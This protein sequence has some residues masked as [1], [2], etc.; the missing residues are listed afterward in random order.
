MSAAA[1]ALFSVSGVAGIATAAFAS[2]CGWRCFSPRGAELWLAR[3]GTQPALTQICSYLIAILPLLALGSLFGA[4]A[5]TAA[6][7]AA[8]RR[9][10]VSLAHAG[11]ASFCAAL[12]AA[13]W[14][15]A[16]WRPSSGNERLGWLALAFF[17]GSVLA[18]ALLAE[19]P[20]FLASAPA[21]SGCR[22]WRWRARLRA[23]PT[24]ARRCSPSSPSCSSCRPPTTTRP[25][26]ACGTRAQRARPRAAARA[27]RRR[28]RRRR[29][30][31]GA[32]P[33]DR[34]RDAAALRSRG[35]RRRV[36]SRAPRLPPL[37]RRAAARGPDG[38]RR[39][40]VRGGAVAGHSRAALHEVPPA[41]DRRRL[42]L[43][44]GG[45]LQR[46]SEHV[47]WP[48]AALASRVWDAVLA[49]RPLA[50]LRRQRAARRR[51]ALAPRAA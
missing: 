45:R 11:A 20:T 41:R 37:L 38:A 3:V 35:V 8:A 24:P 43:R 13:R 9:L 46:R 14:R 49:D 42:G 36:H 18:L 30:R 26:S 50:R 1:I 27:A 31:D 6:S 17:V 10:V 39:R 23:T 2:R 19:P 22:C 29:R 7:D 47:R 34:G 51:L 25:S 40:D 4:A 5:L 32:A 12:A 48:L 15:A 44:V 28:R 33:R 16:A 21:S